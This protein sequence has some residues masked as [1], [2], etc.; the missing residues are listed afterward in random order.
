MFPGKLLVNKEETQECITKRL[1]YFSRKKIHSKIEKDRVSATTLE[2]SKIPIDFLI[3]Y[4]M[5]ED[6]KPFLINSFR[7]VGW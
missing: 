6:Y 3:K 1:L 7:T 5:V 4:D 2:N